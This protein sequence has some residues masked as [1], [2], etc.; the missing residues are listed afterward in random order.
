MEQTDI[1]KDVNNAIKSNIAMNR[2]NIYSDAENAAEVYVSST[3][4][5]E[6]DDCKKEEI[7][8]LYI[9]VYTEMIKEQI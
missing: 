6:D 2:D 5:L 3:L 7:K 8:R 1:E 9:D 4:G